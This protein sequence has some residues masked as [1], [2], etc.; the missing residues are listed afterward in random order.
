MKIRKITGLPPPQPGP[1][2]PEKPP[3]PPPTTAAAAAEARRAA[4]GRGERVDGQQEAGEDVTQRPE[5]R[6]KVEALTHPWDYRVSA[7]ASG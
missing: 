2:P 4:A 5:K 1:P 3:P 6:R 7:A